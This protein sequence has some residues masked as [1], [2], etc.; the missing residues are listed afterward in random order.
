MGSFLIE[1]SSDD[2]QHHGRVEILLHQ[3]GQHLGEQDP[4]KPFGG[5]LVIEGIRPDVGVL[6]QD[7]MQLPQDVLPRLLH[8]L[9]S[10]CRALVHKAKG[11]VREKP[12][13][14]AQPYSN[15]RYI[16]RTQAS[17]SRKTAS[18]SGRWKISFQMLSTVALTSSVLEPK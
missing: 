5:E 7:E 11:V 9:F 10:I 8:L 14:W 17:V 12:G 2:L 13:Y 16:Q 18:S 15:C 1:G 6:L 4:G 3:C